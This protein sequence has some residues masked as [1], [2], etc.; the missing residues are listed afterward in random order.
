MVV[1]CTKRLRSGKGAD[2]Q[3]H[4]FETLSAEPADTA[5]AVGAATGGAGPVEGTS[6]S[7]YP[8]GVS[9]Y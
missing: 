4:G 5:S 6:K 2:L 8:P 7:A 1:V 9:S 3:L